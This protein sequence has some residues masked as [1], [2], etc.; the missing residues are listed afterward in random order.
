MA[1]ADKQNVIQLTDS[2][3]LGNGANKVTSNLSTMKSL[4]NT[5][6][7][8]YHK[9]M[10]KYF[11]QILKADGTTQNN[12]NLI[13]NNRDLFNRVVKEYYPLN[14]HTG[15]NVPSNNKRT[16]AGVFTDIDKLITYMKD[17]DILKN[18]QNIIADEQLSSFVNRF[19]IYKQICIQVFNASKS[20]VPSSID[21]MIGTKKIDK[22]KFNVL[23]GFDVSKKEIRLKQYN[24][25]KKL[26]SF[27]KNNKNKNN[28]QLI[29]KYIIYCEKAIKVITDR[30][31][32]YYKLSRTNYFQD[33]TNYNF[34]RNYINSVKSTSSV[35]VANSIRNL[36][37]K[38]D[39]TILS[40]K[41]KFIESLSRN[42]RNEINAFIA[43][44]NISN[45][46]RK[47]I[48]EEI[49]R[50]QIKSLEGHL[51]SMFTSI[52]Y[53]TKNPKDK[54]QKIKDFERFIADIKQTSG[55]RFPQLKPFENKFRE[56]INVLT[57]TESNNALNRSYK[58]ILKRI[59]ESLPININK[60]EEKFSNRPDLYNNIKTEY[61]LSK[62]KKGKKE[63]NIANK[64]I[65]NEINYFK[66]YGKFK[67][68]SQYIKQYNISPEYL[69]KIKEE[70][71]QNLN[72]NLQ[73]IKVKYV[74]GLVNAREKYL[75]DVVK[76]YLSY[77]RNP[78]K[79]G[80]IKLKNI[81]KNYKNTV[82]EINKDY[83]SGFIKKF[84]PL[85]S[86]YLREEEERTRRKIRILKS[87]IRSRLLRERSKRRTRKPK[88]PQKK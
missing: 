10:N 8:L 58:V 48:L 38:Y 46:K 25:W 53:S 1:Q 87:R 12:K 67:N 59:K 54:R 81:D 85:V 14:K 63:L 45:I 16:T 17:M 9:E 41:N 15:A 29:E 56:K 11:N 57:Q 60:I 51:N 21:L 44:S 76:E 68:N 55:D 20:K 62:S 40:N 84:K 31:K 34:N 5:K 50:R 36:Y 78:R 49:E 77:L 79:E 80:G 70:N 69:K 18:D 66:K 64:I 37:R 24:I 27:V 72:S 83:G 4:S 65:K 71:M 52:K 75:E 2:F 23:A 42:S 26:S 28:S 88:T 39:T 7:N 74:K 32:Q 33:T 47:T 82:S 73:E 43:T 61:N 86:K 3:L 35:E 19:N 6:I 30:M 22:N 13:K